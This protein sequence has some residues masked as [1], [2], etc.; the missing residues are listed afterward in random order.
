MI[1][2][3]RN[4]KNAPA[5]AGVARSQ[6]PKLLVAGCSYVWNNSQEHVCTW[7]YYLKDLLQFDQVHDCSQSGGGPGLVVDAITNEIMTNEQITPQDTMI[8]MMWPDLARSD[9]IVSTNATVIDYHHMSLYHFN[10]HYCNLSIPNYVPD[11]HHPIDHM[12]RA[13]NKL[14][15]FDGRVYQNLLGMTLLHSFLQQRGFHTINL[16]VKNVDPRWLDGIGI[17]ASVYEPVLMTMDP[18]LALDD[19]AE[20]TQARIPDDGHPSSECHLQWTRQ[21]LVPYIQAKWPRL[22]SYS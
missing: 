8:I 7:P 5:V 11:D 15:G 2:K 19:Y 17:P 13:Y 20:I 12:S 9:V 6:L 3:T 4:I 10:Q 16:T 21:H 18:V 1:A 14:T 22:I